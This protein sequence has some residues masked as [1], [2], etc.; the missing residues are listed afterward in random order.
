MDGI[1]AGGG[2]GVA[3]SGSKSDSAGD[4]ESACSAGSEGPIYGE[5]AGPARHAD[6]DS[7]SES[8][9]EPATSALRLA[10]RDTGS[11]TH[12]GT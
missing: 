10:D 4:S 6:S 2:P 3:Y 1:A 7:K 5:L 11:D 9:S 8:E 12:T